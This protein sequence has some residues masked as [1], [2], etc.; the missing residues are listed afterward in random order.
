MD[1]EDLRLAVYRC[2]AA[3]GRPPSASD[4]AAQ[5][6]A[7]SEQIEQGLREL[8]DGRHLVLGEHGQIVMAHPFSAVPLGF[9]VMGRDTLWWGGCAWDSFALPHLLP[10]QGDVLVATRCPACNRPHAWNVG[11]SRPPAGDQVAHLR[12]PAARM[13]DDV[14]DT[15]RHQR[16]FCDQDCIDAWIIATGTEPGYI[17]DL[18][19]LWRLA[20]RWYEGRMDR[21][22]VRRDPAQSSDYLRSVGLSGTFW[23]L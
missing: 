2:F 8:A 16:L 23:G 12:T 5:F 17:M 3:T 1:T 22:Y 9:A 20:S 18:G 11:A 14:V 21:G 6:G 15:C 10:D 4:L 19:T 7:G 13:W